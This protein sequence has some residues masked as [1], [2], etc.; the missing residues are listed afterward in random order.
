VG[1]LRI[2]GRHSVS[3]AALLVVLAACPA[4]THAQETPRA[5]SP[6][7]RTIVL[8]QQTVAGLPATLAVL[9]SAGRVLPHIVVEISGGQKVTTD[10]TGR[11]LFAVPGEPGVLTAQIP[12]HEVSASAPIVKMSDAAPPTPLEDSSAAVRV[13]AVPHFL[14][15]HDRFAVRG[16]GFRVEAESNH[17][18]LSGQPCL[19]LASSSVSLVVLPGLHVPIGTISLHVNVAGHEAEPKSVTMVLLELTGPAE[20]P[21]AGAQ[22]KLAVRV[23]GTRERLAIEV[24]NSSPGIIQFPRGTVE[25]LTSSGGEWNAAEIETKFL[26]SGDYVVTAR[27]IPTDSGLPDLEAARQ[28]LVAARALATG[29]WAAR[30]DRV[31]RRIERDPQD[32]ANIRSE[33][34]RMLN[35]KPP[36]EFAFLLESAWQEFQ[37]NN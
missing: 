30:A 27:L 3:R 26:A 6:S 13:L 37:K 1:S 32:V 14:S 28:K 23:H 8:P 16:A 35:D 12:G 18:Y 19:V 5:Q 36:G 25:R 15:L 17:V 4:F 33:I 2:G 31:I 10:S 7:P 20:A 29:P 21:P 34:E 24:R 11:A 22:D 9:D